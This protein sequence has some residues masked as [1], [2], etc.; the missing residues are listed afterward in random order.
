MVVFK[1]ILQASVACVILMCSQITFAD[2]VDAVAAYYR[3]MAKAG[4]GLNIDQKN[5]QATPTL[6]HGIYRLT[7]KPS[8]QFMSFLNEG[9]TIT[10]DHKGWQIVANPPRQMNSREISEFR[11]EVMRH[12][13]FDRLIKVQYGDGGGRKLVMLSAVDCPFCK[14]FEDNAAKS[15]SSINATFYVLP[16]A[17][18]PI[19]YG[20]IQQWRTATNI[21]CA[22]DNASAWRGFWANKKSPPI[23]QDCVFDEQTVENLGL[24]FGELLSSVGI[25]MPG[26]P[27]IL[28][29]DGTVF[30][31]QPDFDK[32]YARSV[33]GSEALTSFNSVYEEH[34]HSKW[35]D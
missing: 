17:L 4:I 21:W 7:I 34:H 24:Q 12:I 2:G 19:S 6:V 31:P 25:N 20:A 23:T 30:T 1:K 35:L 26:V 9:G 8:G 28:R 3:T 27:S 14:K 15:S 32:N 11:G 16:S 10:G 5:M 22:K 33:F 18:R 29:E 13:D